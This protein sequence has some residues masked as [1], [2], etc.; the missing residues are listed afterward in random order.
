MTRRRRVIPHGVI[1]SFFLES[2]CAPNNHGGST[3]RGI[4]KMLFN[5]HPA[6]AGVIGNVRS[7]DGEMTTDK[8]TPEQRKADGFALHVRQFC[9]H[10]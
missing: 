9:R 7:S 4:W 8:A 5:E 1:E 6:A 3:V 2:T 10:R